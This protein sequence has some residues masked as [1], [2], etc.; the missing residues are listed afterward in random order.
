MPDTE[1]I[2]YRQELELKNSWGPSP[3]TCVTLRLKPQTLTL[4]MN[5]TRPLFS[6]TPLE[7]VGSARALEAPGAKR[8]SPDDSREK[9]VPTGPLNTVVSSVKYES[10]CSRYSAGDRH[11]A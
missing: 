6:D 5:Y 11:E 7:Q 8:G 4:Y 1:P 10:M 3:D 2:V 9:R